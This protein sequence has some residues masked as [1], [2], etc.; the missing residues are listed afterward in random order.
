MEDRPDQ[1]HKGGA[2]THAGGIVV[3]TGKDGR[4]L[5]VISARRRQYDRVLPKGKIE[6]GE[7]APETAVREVAEET[8]VKARVL[9]EAGENAYTLDQKEIRILYFVMEASGGKAENGREERHVGWYSIPDALEILTYPN[10][11]EL[12]RRALSRL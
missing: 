11:R 1:S 10:D 7:T 3:R 9:A 6:S 4:E 12:V 5:L 8:G 2:F